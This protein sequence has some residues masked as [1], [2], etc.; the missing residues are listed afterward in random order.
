M[1]E[2][3]RPITASE[4]A[5]LEKLLELEVEGRSELLQQIPGLQAKNIDAEGSLR[6]RVAGGPLAPIKRDVIAEAQ[7][8][9]TPES[10]SLGVQVNLLLH[11]SNGRLFILE[12]YKDDGTPIARA[13]DPS[14][15]RLFSSHS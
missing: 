14:E 6:F 5:I 15:L 13:P 10:G 3:F 1:L 8:T 7:Y 4:R 11:V 2:A 9:D 12:V